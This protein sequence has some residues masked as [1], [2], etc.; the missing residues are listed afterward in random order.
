M[1]EASIPGIGQQV[2][3]GSLYLNSQIQLALLPTARNAYSCLRLWYVPSLP[4]MHSEDALIW[5]QAVQVGIIKSTLASYSKAGRVFCAA[6]W[7]SFCRKLDIQD[8]K[9]TSICAFCASLGCKCFEAQTQSWWKHGHYASYM[10]TRSNAR[11]S[12]KWNWNKELSIN[13]HWLIRYFCIGKLCIHRHVILAAISQICELVLRILRFLV[14]MTISVQRLLGA[15][16]QVRTRLAFLAGGPLE[17][18]L[19]NLPPAWKHAKRSERPE[20]KGE[21]PWAWH[22]T[23]KTF[24]QDNFVGCIVLSYIWSLT[25]WVKAAALVWWSKSNTQSTPYAIADFTQPYTCF[26]EK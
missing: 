23:S 14:S 25:F 20:H 17:D 16:H 4:R 10:S 19:F 11:K 8:R 13:L 12:F 7:S 6:A 2:G 15:R 9:Q 1:L 5:D 26:A 18:R 21:F 3:S 24:W 22:S